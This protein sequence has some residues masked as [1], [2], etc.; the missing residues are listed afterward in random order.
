MAKNIAASTTQ[1]ASTI[2]CTRSEY[3]EGAQRIYD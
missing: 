3:Q 1:N 2:K